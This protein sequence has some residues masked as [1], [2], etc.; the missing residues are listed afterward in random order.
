M[1]EANQFYEN[2]RSKHQTVM[3][4]REGARSDGGDPVPLPNGQDLSGKVEP[5]DPSNQTPMKDGMPSQTPNP[6][7]LTPN[8]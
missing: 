1:N 8:G 7:D 6:L 3:G 4:W 2:M 5:T